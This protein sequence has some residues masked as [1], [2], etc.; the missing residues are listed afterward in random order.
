MIGSIEKQFIL[1]SS[2][3]KKEKDYWVKRF[4]V[5]L[6]GTNLLPDFNKYQTYRY[7]E[8]HLEICVP[9]DVGSKLIK[10]SKNSDISLFIILLTAVKC[11]I[12]K[13]TGQCNITVGSSVYKQNKSEDCLNS[14]LALYDEVIE[15]ATFK[16]LL[17]VVRQ[18][19]LEAYENQNYPFE[20]IAKSLSI[21]LKANNVPVFGVM[22]LLSNIHD[23][24]DIKDVQTDIIL[25]FNKDMECIKLDSL[26]NSCVF[27]QQTI[28][29]FCRHIITLLEQITENINIKIQDIKLLLK[30]EEQELIAAF[31]QTTTEY[32]KSKAVHKLF[33]DQVE[34][35]PEDI[36][37]VFKDTQLT[38]RQLNEKANQL[39]RLLREK[40]VTAETTVGLMVERSCEM[41]IG[42]LGIL[43]AGGAYVPVDPE[44]PL[45]RKNYMILDSNVHLLLTQSWILD[46]VSFSGDILMLDDN[47]LYTGDTGSLVDNSHPSDLAC[48]I[49]TSGSTGNPKGVMI[50]HRNI[51][52]IT[53]WFNEIYNLKEN[54]N[55]LQMTNFI[56]DPS[57]EQIFGS[58]LFGS[59]VYCIPKDVILDKRKF[60]KYIEDNKINVINFT[61]AT[62]RGLL[63]DEN[64]IHSLNII[65][66]GGEKLDEGLKD[67]IVSKGYCL[68][69]H[70]G[71][72]ETTVD[73]IT[74]RCEASTQVMLGK[75]VF[76]TRVY[77]LN[78][79]NNLQPVGAVGEICISG[80]GVARG[81]LNNPGLTAEKFVSDPFYLGKVMYKTGDRARW[82]PDGNIDF[83]GR[84]D[85]QVKIRGFRIE[86]GEIEKQLL[87][88]ENVKEAVVVDLEDEN[89]NKYLCAYLVLKHG[90]KVLSGREIIDS[91]KSTLPYYFIPSDVVILDKIPLMS[92]GKVNRKALPKLEMRSNSSSYEGP[93]N[94]AE[95]KMINI[96]KEILGDKKIGIN[97]NFFELGGHSLRATQ[98]V[99]KIYKEFNVELPL[100]EVFHTP[101]VKELVEVISRNSRCDYTQIQIQPEMDYYPASSAQKRLFFLRQLEYDTLAYNIPCAFIV[102]GEVDLEKFEHTLSA[103]A[104]RH[105]SLRTSVRL[106]NDEVVQVIRKDIDFHLEYENIQEDEIDY[107]CKN[108]IRAFD[109]ENEPLWRVKIAEVNKNKYLLLFDM[110]HIISDGVSMQI[111]IDEF[112][113]IYAGED[114]DDIKIQYK[115]FTVWQNE[116]LKSDAIHKQMEYWKGIFS[117]EIPVLEIPTD[118]PRPP[119][120]SFEGAAVEFELEEKLTRQLKEMAYQNQATTYMVY[121]A[122][123]NI[124]LSKYSRNEDIIVGSPVAGRRHPDVENVIGMFVNTLAMRNYPEDHKTISQ[125][126]EE[127]RE[128][129]L[130]AYKNQDCQFEELIKNLQITRNLGR[131]PL[132]DTLFVLQNTEMSK[133]DVQ[134]LKFIQYS[135]ENNVTQFDL[136]LDASEEENN[137]HFRFRYCTKLF[138]QE[139]IR[140]MAGHFINIL[141][142]MVNNPKQLIKE[143]DMLSS[144][145]KKQIFVDFNNTEAD[146]PQDKTIHELFEEQVEKH[147][148]R[149]AVIFE[150][151]KMTYKELN[152]KSNRLARTLKRRGVTQ[153]SIVAVMMERSI[154]MMV[155]LMG[156]LKAGGA[157]L[158]IDPTYPED[159]I[160]YMLEDSG[161]SIVLTRQNFLSNDLNGEN[162]YA[163]DPSN[164]GKTCRPENLA[165]V[166]YTS[167]STGKPKGILIEHHSMGN[168]INWMQKKYPIGESDVILQKTPFTFDVSVWELFWWSISGASV[169]FLTPGDEKD[170]EAIVETIYKNNITTMH[171]VPSM[172]NAFLEY[173]DGAADVEKLRSLRQVFASGE[174]LM[175]RQVNKFNEIFYQKLGIRLHNLY[176]PTEAAIDVS[177][178]DCSTGDERESIP[179]GKPID[180]IN[181]LVL[182]RNS[183]LQPIGV[184]G[185]LHI[186]GEG[187]ARGYLNRPELTGEKFVFNP[188]MQEL[189]SNPTY[190]RMY[191][192]GDEA[193]W[194]P[195]GNIEFLGRVDN[196]VKIR[197]FR[198]ELGEIETRLLAHSAVKEA[199]TLALEDENS[200]K[201]ICAYITTKENVEVNQLKALLSRVLP[202]YMVP[203]Y[204]V[205]L[206][207]MPLLPN[208]KIDRKALSKPDK[209]LNLSCKY[210]APQSET[211]EKLVEIWSE[212]LEIEKENIGIR[213]N[214]FSL[215]GDSIKAIRLV[216]SINN[217]MK[218]KVKIRDLY[219]YTNIEELGA[220]IE[221]NKV[222]DESFESVKIK[223][224]LELLK[225]N[226]LK[227]KKLASKLPTDFEDLYPVSDIELGM[228]Y[229][230]LR[231]PQIA[232][233]HDQFLFQIKE[234]DFDFKVLIKAMEYMVKKHPI[235]RL[236]FNLSDFDTIVQIIHKT[237]E[238]DIEQSYI[239]DLDI[240][241]QERYINKY[242]EDD[243]KKPFDISKAP[244]WRIRIFNLNEEDICICW[245][246]HH[247]I[248]DGWS[249]SSFITELLNTYFTLKKEPDFEPEGL[250]HSYKD[251]IIE[252]EA[253]KRNSDIIQYWK[254]E[255]EEYKRLSLPIGKKL[256]DNQQNELGVVSRQLDSK[257]LTQLRYIA[258]KYG[259]DIKT[260]CFAAYVYTFYMNSYENDFVV[261]LVENCR[262]DCEDGDKI[263]GCFLNTVPVRIQFQ[264]KMRLKE[265]IQYVMKKLADLKLY[266]KLPLFEIAKTVGKSTNEDNPLF[267]VIFNYIDFH[268]YN[269][270]D[271]KDIITNR[272]NVEGYER[273]NSVVDFMISTTFNRFDIKL[274]YLKSV[275]E[276][277]QI[278]KL[279]QYF[280][281]ILDTMI[282]DVEQPINKRD[283]LASG[284]REQLFNSF[285]NTQVDYNQKMTIH[286]LF[287][288]QVIK[289][290]GTCAIEFASQKISYGKLNAMANQ[291]ARL[292]VSKGI[293]PGKIVGIMPKRS[294]EMLIGIIGI[295]KAGGAYLPIDPEYPLERIKFILEDSGAGVLLTHPSLADRLGFRG[296][297]LDITDP[298][299]FSGDTSNLNETSKE[300]DLAYV[301]YTSGSMGK[302]KGVMIEHRAV[303]NFIKGITDKIEFLPNK[304]ILALTT[305]SFDIFVLETLLPLTNGLKVILADENQQMDPKLLSK[306][307]T[308]RKVDMLQMTPSRMRMLL[309]DKMGL[310]CFYGVKEIML[311]GEAFPEGLM[312]ELVK[313]QNTKV[314]NMYG[315][316]E[317]TVWSTIREIKSTDDINIGKPIANTRI[318]ILS[319]TMDLQPVGTIGDLYIAGQGLARGYFNNEQLTK[320][321]FIENPFVAGE[322]M[323]KTGDL[324][325]WLHDG[326]IEF[327]GRSDYQ[328]KIRGYRVELGEIEECLN[329]CSAVTQCAVVA[330]ENISDNSKYLA[331]YYVAES[332]LNISEL[333]GYL[334]ESLPVYMIPRA[335]VH[336]EAL[337]LTPNGKIDR[338]ALP[339]PDNS[340]PYLSMGYR[341]PVTH[342]ENEL[343]SV[344]KSVL[345]R[346]LIGVDDNFFELGG[347]SLNV[348]QAQA[349]IDKL[350]P[351]KL[352]IT[353]FF[354]YPTISKL[355]G[356]IMECGETVDGQI[357]IKGMKFPIEYYISSFEEK[358]YTD[359]KFS[360]EDSLLGDIKQ[361]ALSAGVRTIDF[362]AAAFVYLLSSITEQPDIT[363]QTIIDESDFILP[364]HV[365]L[366]SIT[367]LKL[368]LQLINQ[369][370][371]GRSEA[372][373][374]P[375]KRL[376]KFTLVVDKG[377]TI[378]PLICN[379]NIPQSVGNDTFDIVFEV[380]EDPNS[381]SFNISFNAERLRKNKIEEMIHYFVEVMK[382]IIQE[383]RKGAYL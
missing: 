323:Y 162:L 301:I 130:K 7:E 275:F 183:K 257:I 155:G 3:Y 89:E 53:H 159:R 192:T 86:L 6:A 242:L 288:E 305:I 354:A 62:L 128:N 327:C 188:Y 107:V 334:S 69:N 208:G 108:F 232:V 316:T 362:F 83:L 81:Y 125:F 137:T 291:L 42:M 379:I 265:L 13:Y 348:V 78:E 73:A 350:Y 161:I 178:F 227:D 157:Y 234:A 9:Q 189:N 117:G 40:G 238:L 71:P 298:M 343:A 120:Q 259:T 279:V 300:D 367:D 331:A 118:Y 41:V 228:I 329:R 237:I 59:T 355:A 283:I 326:N 34:K 201:Y 146:F 229:Y 297:I 150:G 282:E 260:I 244:M 50:E 359:F 361:T 306:L 22:C 233:Y 383:M 158:P 131:N 20:N 317:T 324:A 223:E 123:Y 75:P 377:N 369:K 5:G 235:L 187:L 64:K 284:E 11:L 154:E 87:K 340:R 21:P 190:T 95:K 313:L 138:R 268:I 209:K 185:E 333:T 371:M 196:Q 47:R 351:G 364:L 25:S 236:S 55:V 210:V 67:V 57:I 250:K 10:M 184:P 96:W 199:I 129:S 374:I 176:G 68:Y 99:A 113:R 132:F 249:N 320:E 37:V 299:L 45:E 269:H 63:A 304:S 266:G 104:Q 251:F 363:I 264:H 39:A 74:S 48:I 338:N 202:D 172:L 61:P 175:P 70:Y 243:K 337:P 153:D 16:E 296:E 36:A 102:E 342:I 381:V 149:I 330:K 241:E 225:E 17:F 382:F 215:G 376:D 218:S 293:K 276:E 115:D 346:E 270:V 356:F 287:E 85:N 205:Q 366:S 82:T 114:L 31:N 274:I 29:Q 319:K 135:L 179:I 211:Q 200:N 285:N 267:D 18:T 15:G 72:T 372:D 12:H 156:I 93:R 88:H 254:S 240:K 90:S 124:L 152:E 8:A 213:D 65:I 197:G 370:I 217:K 168:R 163:D 140:R 177:Y 222:Q 336:M 105:E 148:N 289:S 182:D 294:P 368:Y 216:S 116:L 273:N 345:G 224:E 380:F 357:E 314:Y 191:K 32:E 186:I 164:L 119:M 4:E 258:G 126:M 310:N 19:V 134:G 14:F 2:K 110:H 344:W 166:I 76:N 24:D 103:L 127:I 144:K 315:P 58:L 194:L 204:F 180:N 339:E 133:L 212:V 26:Y 378:I 256:E 231:Y 141:C 91:L 245:V 322:L 106:I 352:S 248:I 145:E 44:Y 206:D 207:A 160:K 142:E 122:A 302:P 308:V 303:Y 167:G 66:C 33:E 325:R 318:Y 92:N 358:K 311:G 255:L 121:L 253:I 353:D 97:D 43:K 347:N 341:E 239:G 272:L 80:E 230:S 262:P 136:V 171:F 101:S 100:T 321:R 247:A 49:Y 94:E 278:Q 51:V 246:F 286:Q 309:N 328:V 28:N 271:R 98:L 365:D 295:L 147:P 170:P 111:F 169:C 219:R 198:I 281:N 46:N 214:F 307:I 173:I 38:Y 349:Q 277:E 23:T 375:V 312:K 181:L 360:L 292:L 335:F 193:R 52:H 27:K 373:I 79:N 1:S 220:H 60:I 290:P 143:I 203:S 226:I 151:Q 261:G 139:T 54:K 332:E 30:K 84:L 252:Q 263:L 195:D 280:I 109:L 112:V 165:Y 174:A 221:S 77:I 56:F 35:S